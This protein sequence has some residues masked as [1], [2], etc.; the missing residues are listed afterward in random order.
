MKFNTSDLLDY[1]YEGLYPE[2]EA[3]EKERKRIV[4]QIVVVFIVVALALLWI[5]SRT[6]GNA[7][8]FLFLAFGAFVLL[9]FVINWLMGSYRR[10][11]KERIFR[12]IVTR[13]DPN[14]IYIPDGMIPKTIFR[15]SGLFSDD[16][17]H[18]DGNDLIRGKIGETPIEFSD[19]TVEKETTDA[20]GRKD[21]HTIF[22]GTFIMT[23]FHKS[24]KH[25][26]MVFPDI[27][28][29]YLGVLGGWLQGMASK[30]L[31]R[32][33]NP[34]FEKEFKVYA[35]DPIEAHYLLTPIIMEKLVALKK[36]ADAPLYLS[37]KYDKLFIAI[38]N[39]GDWFEPTLLKSLLS[40]D[41]FKA[42]IENLNLILGIVEELNLNRR[43]W[44]KE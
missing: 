26:T 41:I 23:E 28:E 13:I 5:L 16:I 1:Y 21:R 22:A 39:G 35:D 43:I 42:Y 7:E 10:R 8:T 44:S 12:K 11:F 17:D 37:F 2:L 15:L 36:R 30:K 29:R 25:T 32:M 20:K 14:L 6:G 9:G 27:A 19:L 34:A 31:V 3:L 4:R 38:A 24:F 18:Y 40:I 33:D